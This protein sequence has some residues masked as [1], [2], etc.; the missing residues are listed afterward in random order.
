M[1]GDADANRAP[2]HLPKDEAGTPGRA[3][4]KYPSDVTEAT[5]S[6][7]VELTDTKHRF[8]SRP[9]QRMRCVSALS[10]VNEA[11]SAENLSEEQC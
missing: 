5:V 3:P 8:R 11:E 2:A 6:V 9:T 7:A 10:D 4:A 1:A